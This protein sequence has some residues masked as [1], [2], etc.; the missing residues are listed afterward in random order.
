MRRPL[1]G[2]KR[3]RE[4]SEKESVPTQSVL[5]KTRPSCVEAEVVIENQESYDDNVQELHLEYELEKPHRKNVRRLMKA[6]FPQRRIWVTSADS[7]TVPD[8]LRQF[9]FLNSSK[10]VSMNA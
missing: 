5:K 6:T 2:Q 3:D 4:E 7:P 1:P 8:V 9:P 10:Y